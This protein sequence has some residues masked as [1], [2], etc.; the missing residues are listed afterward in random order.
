MIKSFWKINFTN[1]NITKF[2][3]LQKKNY[4]IFFIRK[5]RIFNKGRYSRNRQLYRTG[6]YWCLW[7]NIVFV[8][9]T[10]FYFYRYSINFGYM[11]W[12]IAIFMYSMILSRIL[13]YRLYNIK[14]ILKSYFEF[15][16]WLTLIFVNFSLNIKNFFKKKFYFFI[17]KFKIFFKFYI[18]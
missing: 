8:V 9:G 10:Y 14:N 13:K 15:F 18:F 12:G 4:T 1:N 3:D 5:N 11:W 7:F 17:K 6:V 16:N 2:F